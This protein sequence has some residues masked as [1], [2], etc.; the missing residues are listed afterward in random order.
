MFA[1]P[2]AMLGSIAELAAG[3]QFVLRGRGVMGSGRMLVGGG[4]VLACLLGPGQ[5]LRRVLLG[6]LGLLGRRPVLDRL[7]GEFPIRSR[8]SAIRSPSCSR[9][10]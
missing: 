4:G 9:R 6:P 8:S 7:A 5:R 3:E 2:A 10:A 1:G